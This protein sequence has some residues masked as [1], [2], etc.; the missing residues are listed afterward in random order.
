M[1]DQDSSNLTFVSR[2]EQPLKPLII[3][4]LILRDETG[5]PWQITV[6]P[7]GQLQTAK[8][9]DGEPLTM[10]M[11]FNRTALENVGIADDSGLEVDLADNT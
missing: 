1:S 5:Q 11:R 3:E 2:T 7:D 8:Y 6:R 9:P 10:R 4:R